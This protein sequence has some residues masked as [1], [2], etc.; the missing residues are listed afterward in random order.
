MMGLVLTSCSDQTMEASSEG[1]SSAADILSD[2][3]ALAQ[4]AEIDRLLKDDPRTAIFPLKNVFETETELLVRE[5][6]SVTVD[7]IEDESQ[8]ERSAYFGDLHVHTAYSFDG[9]AFGTLA[10]PYDAYRFARGEA[11]KN[12]GGYNMQLS[13]PMDFYA[14]TDHAMFLGLV[15]AAA[16]TSTA[17]SKNEFSEPYN[18]LNAPDNF[19]TGFISS[20][21]RL[22]AF[23][24][25]LPDAVTAV[26][27]GDLDRKEVLDVVRS[28]WS[29]T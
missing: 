14:V 16:D 21:K 3:R 6:A 5:E 15:K 1:F 8:M 12:P 4:T 24:G 7:T 9:Y 22:L 11:I 18:D 10:T 26:L 27:E 13:R 2:E 23:S 28:A 25:F 19:G 20:M 29:D 17:F